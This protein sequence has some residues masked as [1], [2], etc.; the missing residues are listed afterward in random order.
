[1]NYKS[2]SLSL[3]NMW[4]A[5]AAFGAAALLG[6]Y[7]VVERS[8]M[9]PDMQWAEGYFASVTIHGV[10][11]GFVLT[12][13]MIVGSGYWFATT[14]LKQKVWNQGLAWLGFWI[15]LIGVVLAAIAMFSGNATVLFTFYPP[16]KASP[17]FY[18]GATLLVVGSWVWCVQMIV[19]TNIWKKANPGKPVPLI[20]F[21]NT[22]NAILWLF[23][24]L[25]VASEVLFQL[26]PWSMG[27]LETVDVG[28]A[29]VL[30]SWTLHAIVYFWLFPAYLMLYTVMPKVAGGRL[31]SDE[32][33]RI[34]FVMLLVVSVPIGMHH[35][36]VDPMVA[37][38]WKFVT[39]IGTLIVALPTLFTGF[40]VL[41]S[42]EIAGRLRGGKGLFG[43]IRTLPWGEPVVLASG[44]A[45]FMLV[46]GGWG[47]LI[48][49]SYSMNTLVH[50]TAWVTGHFHL[51]FGGTVGIMY[52]AIG[53]HVWPKITGKS[54]SKG[55]AN[56]QLWLWTLG[57]LITTTPWHYLG[58]LGQPRRISQA[59][60][61]HPLVEQ[62]AL[63]EQ[64]MVL[65]GATLVLSALLFLFNLIRVHL[66]STADNSEMEYAEAIHQPV[67]VPKLLNGYGFW[68]IVIV[69][70]LVVSFGY[71]ILQFFLLETHGAFAW[72]I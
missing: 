27:W 38:G 20:Q 69:L 44:L 41:A 6:L 17:L 71:P 31:F 2:N 32:L 54:L 58:V 9:F 67:H 24:T 36:Y 8:G 52:F 49:A 5:F 47:G 26:I 57:M 53:Y 30:F 59:V 61:D 37:A 22:A 42:M 51:I 4:V 70:Y 23:T 72:D 66:S 14:S 68:S 29:R 12:T 45:M 56:L 19:M 55:A 1:M 34:S 35:L 64:L 13:F 10:L 40:T 33:G 25:G 50:N 7:Q 16:L 39:M 21:G 60:Y 11:M 46:F 62:W 18:I 65:G 3:A 63:H 15:M 28:L 48:N 43:W